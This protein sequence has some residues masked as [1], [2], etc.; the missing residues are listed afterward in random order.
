MRSLEK[1]DTW[2]LTELHAGKRALLNKWVFRIKTEPEGKRRFKA[3][4]VVKGNSQRKGIDYV[5]IFS[6]VVKLTSIRI[7]LSVV[8]SESLHL[9]KMD[10]KTTFLHGDLDKEIYMQQPEGFVVPGK[11]RMVCKLTRSLYGLNQAPRQWYK[12][13]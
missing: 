7:L 11:E 6:L 13:F 8:A 12:K 10:V 3:R 5:E 1:T 9:E 2:V 4:L